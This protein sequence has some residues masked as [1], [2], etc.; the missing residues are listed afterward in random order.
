[1]SLST[2]R[3]YRFNRM[4]LAGSLGDLGTLLP[5]ALGM[6]LLNGMA[7]TNVLLTFGLSYV[8]AG[9]YFGVPVAVQPMK[10]IAAYAIAAELAPQQI[11]A[12]GLWMA[13]LLLL[14]GIT[15]LI[16][17]ISRVTPKSTVRGIQLSVGIVLLVK[18]FK[19]LVAEDP[20]LAVR[21]LG[22]LSTGI[23]IGSAGLV[24]TFLLLDNR[25]FP[26]ALVVLVLGVVCGLAVGKPVDLAGLLAE[27]QLPRPVPYGWPSWSTLLW[28]LPV[29]VLPQ[30]PLTIGNAVIS[31]TDLTHEYFPG[32]ASKVTH[33]S[34]TMS[35]GL[36]NLFSF[37]M[38]GIPVC[39]GAGG[40]AAHYRFGAR[41]G[42]SNLCIGGVI[43]VIALGFGD[44][45]VALL[46]L[47]PVSILGVLLVFAGL[48]LALMI[49]D[50]RERDDLFVAL[51]M[52]G[53]ALAFNLAV[54]FGVGVVVAYWLRRRGS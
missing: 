30:L 12:S 49:R 27:P 9:L 3:G 22:P 13:G 35:Q 7:A 5:L 16:D 10:A 18:G 14:L 42:G 26:A 6:I 47:M 21:T 44:N 37:V 54:A 1:M 25:R 19:L 43:L 53:L 46:A 48:E 2:L 28:V 34:M 36:A 39:H 51:L 45:A 38:G 17:V 24:L 33:R 29:L 52:L 23:V 15:G 31:S 32:S 41:T 50:L 8:I 20:N 11:A 4:E 40:V